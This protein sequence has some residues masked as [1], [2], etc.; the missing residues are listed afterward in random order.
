LH[1]LQN[2]NTD[3]HKQ[4]NALKKEGE[5]KGNPTGSNLKGASSTLKTLE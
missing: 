5:K 3:C 4:Q 1:A 2:I